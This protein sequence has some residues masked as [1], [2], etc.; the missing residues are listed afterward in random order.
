MT[1]KSKKYFKIKKCGQVIHSGI[2]TTKENPIEWHH[3]LFK[4]AKDLK[5]KIFSTPFD[6]KL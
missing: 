3:K 1:L 6:K 2:Y 4:L 5:I